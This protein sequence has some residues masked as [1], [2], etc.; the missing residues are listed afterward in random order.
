MYLIAG[1][2]PLSHAFYTDYKE[3]IISNKVIILLFLIGIV[4]MFFKT[5]NLKEIVILNIIPALFV[6]LF[7]FLLFCKNEKNIGAGDIK[8]YTAYIFTYSITLFILAFFIAGSI[9]LF[10]AFI[11]KEKFVPMGEYFFQAHIIICS[12][13]L[14]T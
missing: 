10:I 14:I 4:G 1:L 13:F 6:F 11:N 12:I 9:G 7:S 5:G 3:R 8:L 2:F